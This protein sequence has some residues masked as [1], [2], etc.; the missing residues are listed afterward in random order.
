MEST[1]YLDLLFH[2]RGKDSGA[3]A[4]QKLVKFLLVYRARDDALIQGPASSSINGLEINSFYVRNS[5]IRTL[6][7]SL[8]F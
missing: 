5:Y 3:V 7:A 2:D 6:F 8:K 1:V 4:F